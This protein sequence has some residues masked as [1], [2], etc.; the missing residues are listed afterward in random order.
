M[1]RE[2]HRWY[3][4]RVDRE[5]GLVVYGHWG[6]PILAFPTSGGDEGEL[7]RMGL[8]P[9]LASYIEAGRVKVYC[10]GSNNHDSFYNT[11]AHPFHRSWMQ[12]MF[13]EYIRWEVI[14]FVHHQCGGLHAIG[15]M[16]ASLGG[17]HAA[18]TLLKHPDAVKVAWALSGVYD[19]RR[20]MDGLSDDNFYF[21]NPVD[22]VGGLTDPDRIALLNTCD[23]HI[24]TGT[25][26]WERTA[27]AYHFS[28]LLGIKG[29]RHSLDDWGPAGG[30]DWPYW[31][32]QMREY[33]RRF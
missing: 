30:H 20:F 11:G 8:I 29:I 18:N 16:G 6:F 28:H 27:E 31:Q 19:M 1:H 4:P 21:N 2:Q 22:Y 3:S 23:L 13:D 26:P 24:A 5:M 12:R 15:A 25:G 9:A 7:E 14:P 32:H 17:Y 33:L 10:V